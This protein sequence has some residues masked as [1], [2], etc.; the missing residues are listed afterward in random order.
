MDRT[1][2]PRGMPLAQ[3]LWVERKA[4][5]ASTSRRAGSLEIV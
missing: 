3:W 1:T 2:T 5:M 4:W